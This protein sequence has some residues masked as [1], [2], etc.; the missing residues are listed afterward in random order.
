VPGFLGLGPAHAAGADL[1]RR[2]LLDL[3]LLP[4]G[5]FD[6]DR[7]LLLAR[8]LSGERHVGLRLL[9]GL[10]GVAFERGLGFLAVRDRQAVEPIGSLLLGLLDRRLALVVGGGCARLV[11]FARLC[12]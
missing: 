9:A 7:L 3:H 2:G 10:D 4:V 5:G 12:V 8:D 1:G 6:L 11:L